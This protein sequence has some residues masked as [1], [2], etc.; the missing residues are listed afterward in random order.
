M[1]KID[2]LSTFIFRLGLG[3]MEKWHKIDS[4]L[5]PKNNTI[6]KIKIEGK[7]ICLINDG[8]NYYATGST[9]PHAGADLSNGWCEE[10]RLVCPYHR[11]AFN[12]KSGRGDAGQGNY[13]NTYPIKGQNGEYFIGL[14]VNWVKKLL[15]L[16]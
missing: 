2:K 9:C 13:I 7:N 12:L 14:P 6:K 1:R 16:G 10:G 8:N 5:L 15:G 4:S 3:I 11:H